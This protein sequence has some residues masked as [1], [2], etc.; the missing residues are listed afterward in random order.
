MKANAA[1]FLYVR[2]N[3]D[4]QEFVILNRK[5]EVIKLLV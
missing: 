1:E 2:Y 3:G 4:R 5:L